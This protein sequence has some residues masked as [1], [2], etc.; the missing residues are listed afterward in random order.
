[1]GGDCVITIGFLHQFLFPKSLKTTTTTTTAT[2]TFFKESIDFL[3][4]QS[5]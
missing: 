4:I 3:I 2:T 1:M 5:I